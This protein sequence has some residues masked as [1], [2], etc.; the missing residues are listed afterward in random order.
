MNMA[1]KVLL[2]AVV[3]P[4]TMAAS[5]AFAA[6]GPQGPK[7]DRTPGGVCGPDGE[8]SILQQL[9]LSKRQTEQLKELHK[10]EHKAMREEMKALHEEEQSIV[11]AK[12]FDQAKATQLAQKLVNLQVQRR[13]EMMQ[14]RHDLMAILTPEQ[15]GQFELLQ[16]YRMSQCMKGPGMKGPGF[17]GRPDDAAEE[18][19][20]HGFVGLGLL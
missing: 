2:A 20:V 3:L 4:L 11:L 16:K 1:K 15:K 18:L 17:K 5:G 7:G 9:N 13:V 12:D 8:Q 19:L 10:K 14:Q 6:G